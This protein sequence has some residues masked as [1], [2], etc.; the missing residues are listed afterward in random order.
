MVF[1]VKPRFMPSF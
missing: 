1:I